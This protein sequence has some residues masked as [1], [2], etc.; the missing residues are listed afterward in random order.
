MARQRRRSGSRGM[1]QWEG[2]VFTGTVSTTAETFP[3]TTEALA[4][5]WGPHTIL[6][7]KAFWFAE[8]SLGSDRA[9]AFALSFRKVYLD[10]K[11]DTPS[12]VAG[13]IVDANY[14]A[15]EEL[16]HYGL[17]TL[18]PG[19]YTFRP[20][21]DQVIH[22]FRPRGSGMIDVKAKRRYEGAAERMVIDL[23]AIG[24]GISDQITLTIAFRLLVQMH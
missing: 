19:T 4:D 12:D 13:T 8:N 5:D 3:V 11:S 6:R 15:N 10:R 2:I 18:D 21:D 17:Y 7:T 9:G 14:L 22:T 23:E 16:L 20:S 1:T 24:T